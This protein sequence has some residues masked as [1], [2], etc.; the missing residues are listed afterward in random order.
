MELDF[1]G[2]NVI[3]IL[4]VREVWVSGFKQGCQRQFGCRFESPFP[5]LET[6]LGGGGHVWASGKVY[7][8]IHFTPRVE[9]P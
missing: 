5:G 4:W 1:K 2:G 9:F 3:F 8:S 7:S 6:R